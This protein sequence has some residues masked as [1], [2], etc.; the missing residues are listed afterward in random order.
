MN[1]K[2]LQNIGEQ[3]VTG[4]G[5]GPRPNKSK[6]M[7]VQT[8]AEENKRYVRHVMEAF[9]LP[10]IDINDPEQVRERIEWYFD[11]CMNNGMKPTV[12]GVC[13]ALKIDRQTFYRW[14][15]G[16]TRS[17]SAEYCH[18]VK[19]AKAA[20]WELWEQ[21]AADGKVNPVTFIFL[22]KNH[23]GYAD[24]QEVVVTPPDPAGDAGSIEELRERYRESV[25]ID[26]DGVEV[27]GE[28]D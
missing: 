21:F 3:A 20:I 16:K 28:D 17:N 26:T 25:P 11:H 9:R 6:E 24:K 5:K 14:G 12:A 27:D 22:M 7:S 18:M 1:E 10:P 19:S 13:N 2:D 4:K 8:T 15:E 23:F